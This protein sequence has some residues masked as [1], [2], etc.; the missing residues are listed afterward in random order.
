MVESTKKELS[1]E[2]AE[3]KYKSLQL[4]ER[5]F[6]CVKNHIEIRPVFHYKETR[7]KGH[8]FSCFMSYYLLHKFK[9]QT[10]ELLKSNTLDEL[11]TELK[12]I[13][14][15]NFK[16][17]KFVLEKINTLTDIQ[18]ELFSIFQIRVL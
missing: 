6:D 13:K 4:V 12:C 2:E 11:L 17:D 9:Q 8:I 15:V 5:A 1:G 16:I 18:K 14:K 3:K 10:K 7:I